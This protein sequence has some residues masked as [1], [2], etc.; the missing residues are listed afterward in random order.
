MREP[1]AAASALRSAASSLDLPTLD[2]VLATRRFDRRQIGLALVAALNNP[3][4]SSPSREAGPVVERLLALNPDV[5][6]RDDEGR[7]ALHGAETAEMVRQLVALG[8]DVEA[9]AEYGDTPLTS[10]Y[11]EDVILALIDA[12]A[13]VTAQPEYGDDVRETAVRYNLTRVLERLA[14]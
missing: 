11:D 12:G 7:T 2:V 14:R 5:R 4:H 8:A 6:V 1:E 9:R 10:A 13:D 3:R